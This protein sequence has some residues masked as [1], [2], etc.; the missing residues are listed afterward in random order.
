M[1]YR[2]EVT[3]NNL[4]KAAGVTSQGNMRGDTKIKINFEVE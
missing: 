3:L 2:S 1:I 4:Q